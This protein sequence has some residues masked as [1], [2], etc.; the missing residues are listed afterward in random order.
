MERN[1]RRYRA[2]SASAW[3]TVGFGVLLISWAA[4]AEQTEGWALL[5][6]VLGGVL[7]VSALIVATATVH[8]RSAIERLL[9]GIVL[10]VVLIVSVTPLIW[11]AT[12]LDQL[13]DPSAEITEHINCGLGWGL[14]GI[15]VAVVI[16][17]LTV[18]FWDKS[19]RTKRTD[20]DEA[21]RRRP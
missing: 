15:L 12:P 5:R 6:L 13:C 10:W 21:L 7:V 8:Q 2:W 3:L 4:A 1:V 9:W 17:S 16:A 20:T 14:A 19:V 18:V 11:F